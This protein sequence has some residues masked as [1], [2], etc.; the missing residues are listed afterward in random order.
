MHKVL[1]PNEVVLVRPHNLAWL[2]RPELDQKGLIVWEKPDGSLFAHEANLGEPVI[3]ILKTPMRELIK[4][5]R[6]DTPDK[7]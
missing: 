1:S 7:G 4:N 6:K 5:A 3:A 2:R